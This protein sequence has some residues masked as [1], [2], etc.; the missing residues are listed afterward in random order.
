MILDDSGIATGG[1]SA[2]RF[3]ARLREENISAKDLLKPSP[4][5]RLLSDHPNHV[6]QFDVTNCLQYFLDS[7]KG[8]GERDT[9]MT[10]YKNKIVKTAK[11]IKKELLRYA[12]VDHCSGAF[13]FLYYYASGERA[14]DGGNFLFHAMRP[15]DELIKNTWPEVPFRVNG[16]AAPN[17]ANTVSTACRSCSFLIAVPS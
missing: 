3:I 9:E 6:W 17:S 10:M 2:N 7:K 5:Q 4:H 8:L 12:V 1:V 16:E 14:V 15:K 11:A 13:F